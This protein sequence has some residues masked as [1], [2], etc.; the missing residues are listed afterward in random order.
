MDKCIE[1]I[2]RS[3]VPLDTILDLLQQMKMLAAA[4]PQQAKLMLQQDP[5]LANAMFQTMLTMG[6]VKPE[7]LMQQ[8]V[9]LQQTGTT[10][11]PVIPSILQ[12]TA[13]LPAGSVPAA[14]GDEQTAMILR[15][16]SLTPE[17]IAALPAGEQQAIRLIRQSLGGSA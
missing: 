2:Q 7:A 15:V 5:K 6:V 17:Q 1:V 11:P 12:P 8:V 13:P 14:A 4:A 9:A 16:L 10:Q 3:G